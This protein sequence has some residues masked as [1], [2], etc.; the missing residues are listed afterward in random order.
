MNKN[1]KYWAIVDNSTGLGI[2][3]VVR[4]VTIESH[5]REMEM[6]DVKI[7]G[8]DTYDLIDIG[9]LFETKEEANNCFDWLISNNF[10]RYK[11]NIRYLID[12]PIYVSRYAARY[13]FA[14]LL[15][16]RR[17]TSDTQIIDLYTGEVI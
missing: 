2:T 17:V 12:K 13:N 14:L 6:V 15:K 3:Y 4:P 16:R 1:K 5:L 9:R 11:I 10:L 7:E 8:T